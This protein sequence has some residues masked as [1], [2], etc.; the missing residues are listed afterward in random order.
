M[1]RRRYA[2]AHELG[3]FVYASDRARKRRVLRPE[4]LRHGLQVH[5]RIEAAHMGRQIAI[6]RGLPWD[7]VA[8]RAFILL[9]LGVALW[10]H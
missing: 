4:H 2:T 3:Q 6:E 1:D 8:V 5:A 7:W 10:T 9:V